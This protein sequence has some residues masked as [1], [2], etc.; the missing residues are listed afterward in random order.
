MVS[1]VESLKYNF[2]TSMDYWVHF[3][4]WDETIKTDLI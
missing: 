1:L 4:Y 2:V 3:S